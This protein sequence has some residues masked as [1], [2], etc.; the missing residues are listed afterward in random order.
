MSTERDLSSD[1][2]GSDT[3]FSSTR[4]RMAWLSGSI[5]PVIDS[6]ENQPMDVFN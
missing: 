6:L 2:E 1:C 4:I 5:E 3:G